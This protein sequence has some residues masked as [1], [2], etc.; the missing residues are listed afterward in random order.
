[1]RRAQLVTTFGPGALTISPDGFPLL[2]SGLDEW[3]TSWPNEDSSP[4]IEEFVF[5]DR[6]LESRLGVAA[7]RL[8][9]DYRSKLSDRGK[10]N[11]KL[12]VP[13]YL[14]PRWYSCSRCGRLK[15][16]Q[17]NDIESRRLRRDNE[18]ILCRVKSEVSA[19]LD[20]SKT[21]G[22]FRP[23]PLLAV[24]DRGHIQDFPFRQWVH[25]SANPTCRRHMYIFGLGGAVEQQVIKCACGAERRL[26]GILE[27]DL[28]SVPAT[29]IVTNTLVEGKEK[30]GCRGLKAWV[31]AVQ[32]K[33]DRPL[34]GAL[35]TG[36][37]VYYSDVRSSIFLPTMMGPD[38][39]GVS[40]STLDALE[41]ASVEYLYRSLSQD[42]TDE[43]LTFVAG[44]LSPQTGL[45][46]SEVLAGLRYLLARRGTPDSS[47]SSDFDYDER[48]FRQDEYKILA[49][50]NPTNTQH[51]IVEPAALTPWLAKYFSRIS[52]VRRL[53]ETR[54]L[55]GFSRLAPG[56]P[57]SL[58]QKRS[59]LWRD[60]PQVPELRWLPGYFVHGEG[61]FLEIKKDLVTNLK[62]SSAVRNR[63]A[64]AQA[65]R[66]ID[67]SPAFILL[68]TLAHL[69]IRKLSFECGYGAAALRE[70]L[71]VLTEP[72]V[73]MHGILIYTAQSD[74]EGSMGGLVR[75][76]QPDV[77]DRIIRSALEEARW[78]SSD[79]V[80]RELGREVGQGPH[81]L[82]GAA[83]HACCHLPETS[84]ECFNLLLDRNILIGD[85]AGV[86]G[87][88]SPA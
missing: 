20:C 57:V 10:P 63:L 76:G 51:L 87:A 53:R 59:M 37:N 26:G 11:F 33:C 29:S 40:Q 69:L 62:A 82:N 39:S 74:S 54:A 8:P 49:S 46:P 7:F 81:H 16:F 42:A 68:H 84:C 70:R 50:E 22:R 71:Y 52:L 34:V 45:A 13:A 15:C 61:I 85:E 2:V 28:N 27:A 24:C 35:S 64:T 30:F 77:L 32:E 6:R 72:T 80:C 12:P 79:P 65:S 18:E 83:C 31:G 21:P 19:T 14:F 17:P 3:F 9:P 67:R 86:G 55:A 43:Q 48:I 75:M 41:G 56:A 1:M 66:I 73:A 88:L 38:S 78:C 47:H 60:E 23:V 36:T 58:R 44:I 5:H 4:K 25:K